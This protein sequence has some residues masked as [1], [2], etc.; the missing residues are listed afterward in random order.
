MTADD[1]R[2]PDRPVIF[3]DFDGPLTHARYLASQLPGVEH[4]SPQDEEWS[5]R[6]DPAAVARVGRIMEATGA[7]VVVISAWRQTMSTGQLARHLRRRGLPLRSAYDVDRTPVTGDRCEE[8]RA[9]LD[10]HA[11]VDRFVVI[12]DEPRAWG[13]DRL[14]CPTWAEGLTDADVDR[15]VAILA[16]PTVPPGVVL[17]AYAAG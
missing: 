4:H 8:I 12:D 1:A 13:P 11:M 7:R 6:L 15:A 2:A 14:V 9:W 10:A 3:L 5:D 16:A 17:R